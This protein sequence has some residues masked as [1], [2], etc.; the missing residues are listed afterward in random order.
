L[1][2]S[3]IEKATC[4]EL[5]WVLQQRRRSALNGIEALAGLRNSKQDNH[6]IVWLHSLMVSLLYD[7][8]NC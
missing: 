5:H 8:N 6:L 7:A 3:G 4:D 1:Q 2:G